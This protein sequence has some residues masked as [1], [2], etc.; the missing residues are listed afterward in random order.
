MFCISILTEFLFATGVAGVNGE[1]PLASPAK[2]LSSADGAYEHSSRE[3]R[4]F[5][6]LFFH[7]CESVLALWRRCRSP[8]R[9]RPARRAAARRRSR[10]RRRTRNSACHHSPKPKTRRPRTRRAPS[11]RKSKRTTTNQNFPLLSRPSLRSSL[12]QALQVL[13][14]FTRDF[15]AKRT[16]VREHEHFFN[17]S[18]VNPVACLL[19]VL[20]VSGGPGAAV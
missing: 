16:S 6:G 19:I 17:V 7:C 20:Q 15:L 2:S 10:T 1:Q 9:R 8:R 11:S 12:A 3:V 13:C 4:T 18:P 5:T 14:D